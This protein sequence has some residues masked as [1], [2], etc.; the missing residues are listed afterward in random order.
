M[1]EKLEQAVLAR[2]GSYDGAENGLTALNGVPA[3]R[4]SSKPLGGAHS[5]RNV[6][7][8]VPDFADLDVNLRGSLEAGQF[9]LLN[10]TGMS[11]TLGKL[12]QPQT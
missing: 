6:A 3:K 7:G 1:T 11:R 5:N 9:G 12:R 8:D 2:N 10:Q 4:S